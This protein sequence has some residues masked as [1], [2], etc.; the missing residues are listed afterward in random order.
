MQGRHRGCH[1]DRYWS[2][3]HHFCVHPQTVKAPQIHEWQC[4]IICCSLQNTSSLSTPSAL[5]KPFNQLQPVLSTPCRHQMPR[6]AHGEQCQG[7]PGSQ[8]GHC[9]P[10]CSW[11]H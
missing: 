5:A 2:S 3:C 6:E 9:A 11:A 4:K 8:L 1:R 10:R 7:Q